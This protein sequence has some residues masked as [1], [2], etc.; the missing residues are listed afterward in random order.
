MAKARPIIPG[1]NP[2]SNGDRAPNR[3][4]PRPSERNP[5]FREIGHRIITEWRNAVTNDRALDRDHLQQQISELLRTYDDPMGMV[6]IGVIADP[7]PEQDRKFV[8]I[9]VPYPE[10]PAGI[11]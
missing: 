10:A 5:V 8:W 9:V 6:E 2:N 1:R 11:D 4:N 7:K 3:G